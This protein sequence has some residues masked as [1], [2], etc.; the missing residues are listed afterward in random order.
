MPRCAGL[1][2]F[3]HLEHVVDVAFVNGHVMVLFLCPRKKHASLV[4]TNAVPLD[5]D[6]LE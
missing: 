3:P 5:L 6:L 1:V 4:A 2:P